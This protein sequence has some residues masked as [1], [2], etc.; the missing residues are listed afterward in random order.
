MSLGR[1]FHILTQSSD[2]GQ[3]MTSAN[4]LRARSISEAWDE[5]APR[6]ETP[7]IAA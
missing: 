3:V 4:L 1:E 2:T 5:A 7:E 6:C